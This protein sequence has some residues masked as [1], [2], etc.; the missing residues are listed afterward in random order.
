MKKIGLITIILITLSFISTQGKPALKNPANTIDSVC[1]SGNCINGKGRLRI[2]TPGN[3]EYEG[4]FQ[5][6]QLKGECK[7]YRADGSLYYTGTV[8]NFL[9]DGDGMLY[10]QNSKKEDVVIEEGEFINGHLVNGSM[11][12]TTGKVIASGEFVPDGTHRLKKG[13]RSLMYRGKMAY[14]FCD[15]FKIVA[16]GSEMNGKVTVREGD[17]KKGL[18]LSEAIYLNNKREGISKEWDHDNGV[19]HIVTFKDGKLTGPGKIYKTV[20]DQLVAMD[21]IYAP[22]TEEY[23]V[24]SIKHGRFDVN[25][26]EKELNITTGP[27]APYG[28]YKEMITGTASSPILAGAG[29]TSNLKFGRPGANDNVTDNIASGNVSLDDVKAA[30]QRCSDLCDYLSKQMDKA[31]DIITHTARRTYSYD[32]KR[33]VTLRAELLNSIN[34]FI[35]GNKNK[36]PVSGIRLL[37]DYRRAITDK[38]ALPAYAVLRN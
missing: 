33:L 16:N 17:P 2:T 6:G 24:Q 35:A 14:L 15:D 7:I 21:I 13:F 1:V 28:K 5:N 10:E 25:G 30:T 37:E 12:I 19:Y 8:R 11:Y 34:D 9:P 4:F 3:R 29:T 32:E 22:D 38:M 23:L 20:D 18:V 36:V 26:Y 31:T 27:G